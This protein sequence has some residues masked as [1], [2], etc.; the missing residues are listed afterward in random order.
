MVVQSTSDLGSR[1][2]PIEEFSEI[3]ALASRGD[4]AVA[5]AVVCAIALI[6]LILV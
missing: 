2:R 4:V 5:W 3:V 1:R 6:A